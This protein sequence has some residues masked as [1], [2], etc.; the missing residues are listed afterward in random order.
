MSVTAVCY[1]NGARLPVEEIAK[2]AHERG[3]L[4]LLDAYQAVGSYPLDVRELGVDALA[5]GVLKYLLGFAG[6]GFLWTGPGWR[7]S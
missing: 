3:A 2:I 6:L 5:A 4:C 1:R 7:T